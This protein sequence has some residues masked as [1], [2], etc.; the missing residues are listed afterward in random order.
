M[1]VSASP[2]RARQAPG[3]Q[4]WICSM[5]VPSLSHS[6]AKRLKMSPF[7]KK[8]SLFD[9]FSITKPSSIILYLHISA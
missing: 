8:K 5:T 3:S 2:S 6:G 1:L 4:G 9:M 7:L